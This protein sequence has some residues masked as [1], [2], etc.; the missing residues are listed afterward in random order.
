MQC[1]VRESQKLFDLSN[2]A[3]IL[4]CMKL[5]IRLKLYISKLNEEQTSGTKRPTQTPFV[6]VVLSPLPTCTLTDLKTI[7]KFFTALIQ[8]SDTL[9]LYTLILYDHHIYFHLQ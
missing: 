1:F 3:K 6:H 8:W 7:C 4:S 2:T 5:H 9:I